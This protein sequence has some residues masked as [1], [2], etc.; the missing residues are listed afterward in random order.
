MSISYL[1]QDLLALGVRPGGALL[2][3][4]SLRALG[5]LPPGGA[6]DVIR[7]LLEALGPDGT[8]L[9][10]ALSYAS[11]SPRSPVFDVLVTP[12]CVGALPEF[13]RTR[14]G[15]LRSVHPTHS[16]CA[17][18]RL[19]AELQGAQNAFHWYTGT[20]VQPAKLTAPVGDDACLKCHENVTTQRGRNNHFHGFM[21]RWQAADPNA[22]HCVSCHSGHSTTTGTAQTNF[23]TQQVDQPVCDSC[24]RAIRRGD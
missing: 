15:T 16:V 5:P 17:L 19:A 14:P 24:H 11:V 23:T 21:T 18:G 10:P 22:G 3:H 20:A 8:L 1:V 9:M 2:V 7:G 4:A 12:S 6:E 13:F